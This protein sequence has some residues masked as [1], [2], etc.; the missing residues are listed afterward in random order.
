[1]A[2]MVVMAVMATMALRLGVGQSTREPDTH[3]SRTP[4]QD[5]VRFCLSKLF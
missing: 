3:L 2:D 1:M 5:L 4:H